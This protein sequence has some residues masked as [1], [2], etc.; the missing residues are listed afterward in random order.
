VLYVRPARGV[1]VYAPGVTGYKPIALSVQPQPGLLVRAAQYPQSEDYYFRPL[2]EHVRVYQR[3]FRIVQ[4]IVIDSSPQAEAALKTL[5]S[6]TING[7]LNY[8]AC[9]DKVCF[10][11]QSV[12]LTWT[13]NVRPLDRERVK[14]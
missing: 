8:Q 6:L 2:N 12:P 13:V 11:P 4:D 7:V 14:Q 5:T 3:S 10:T 1:H 9:D